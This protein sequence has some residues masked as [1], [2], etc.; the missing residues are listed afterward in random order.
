MF[1]RYFIELPL[2]ADVVEDVM[3]ADP[4]AWLAPIAQ[5]ANIRGDHLLADVGIGERHRLERTVE[6]RTGD[7]I[8]AAT[9][10]VVPLSWRAVG[11]TRGLFPTLD[12]DLE[13]APLGLE[14]SHLAISA[15]YAP[16][17][18]VIGQV[19]DRALLHRIAEAT[20]KDFLDNVAEAVRGLAA[21]ATSNKGGV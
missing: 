7:P 17:L 6:I 4:G 5:R 19:L 12:A 14:A 2:R 10:T 13:I 16:P 3:T 11:A 1:A 20:L 9:K 21:R 8:R 15:R 18:G